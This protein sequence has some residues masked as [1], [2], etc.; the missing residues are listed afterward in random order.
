ME[1][2]NVPQSSP[3]IRSGAGRG[4]VAGEPAITI[5]ALTAAVN[6][7]LVLLFSFAT[8]FTAEQQASVLAFATAVVPVLGALITR[9]Q[10]T[11]VV[12]VETKLETA[13]A[14]G[15]AGETLQVE[16]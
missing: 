4:V 10:V 16:A 12:K 3:M 1:Q 9:T 11:P 5:G 6:A 7:A 15:Q 8:D 2:V 13:H 14:A